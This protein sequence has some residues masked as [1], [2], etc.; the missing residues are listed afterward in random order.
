MTL[1]DARKQVDYR[2]AYCANLYGANYKREEPFLKV[3]KEAIDFYERSPEGFTDEEKR[4][5]GD[6][7][8]NYYT[9]NLYSIAGWNDTAE[10]ILIKLGLIE[11]KI[12]MD[13]ESDDIEDS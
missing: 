9:E 4:F 13:E 3:C 7:F 8:E 6:L 10:S 11:P 2:L 12:E 5:I 1:E